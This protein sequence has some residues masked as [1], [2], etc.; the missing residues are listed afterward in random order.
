FFASRRRHTRFSRDWRSDVCSSD[1]DV[2]DEAEPDILAAH[3]LLDASG[4]A[5][6]QEVRD[7]RPVAERAAADRT[8]LYGHVIVDEAQE[9]SP[10]AWRALMRRCPARS[11][12]IVGDIDRKRVVYGMRGGRG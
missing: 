9:L 4:L 12:T 8:W 1:L 11:M 7:H 2:E 10:M 6:R 3:D 5:R